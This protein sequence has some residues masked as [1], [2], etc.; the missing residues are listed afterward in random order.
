MTKWSDDAVVGRRRGRTDVVGL[1]LIELDVDGGD[2]V[3]GHWMWTGYIQLWT[4]YPTNWLQD[5]F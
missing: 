1:G 4:E 3:T 2:V 5:D